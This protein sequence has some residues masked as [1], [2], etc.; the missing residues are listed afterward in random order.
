L[1]IGYPG[2]DAHSREVCGVQ[3]NSNLLVRFPDGSLDHALPALEMASDHTVMAIFIPGIGVAEEEH[4]V[5]T[6][7]ENVYRRWES[8]MH[9]S[10]LFRA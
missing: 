6:E 8:G 7:E 5:F 10:V 9:T 1:I 3:S 4:V 2:H